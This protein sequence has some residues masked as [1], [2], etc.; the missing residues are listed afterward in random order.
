MTVSNP[1]LLCLVLFVEL[2]FLLRKATAR[3]KFQTELGTLG[4]DSPTFTIRFFTS[5]RVFH[6]KS[7]N[8]HQKIADFKD[9]RISPVHTY[10]NLHGITLATD[11]NRAKILR[12]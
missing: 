12:R 1:G 8:L 6:W 5:I 2:E 4:L 3:F 10:S 11:R 9:W 7:S